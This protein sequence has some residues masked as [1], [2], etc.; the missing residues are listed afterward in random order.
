MDGGDDCIAANKQAELVDVYAY[1]D[2]I[3]STMGMSPE[4]VDGRVR[5]RWSGLAA[6]PG[7]MQLECL[8]SPST[9]TVSS[10]MNIPGGEIS[11]ECD[12][13]RVWC[14][15]LG[16]N[17]NMSTFNMKTFAPNGTLTATQSLSILPTFTTALGEP[18]SSFLRFDC[19]VYDPTSP[20]APID[21]GVLSA[22][23]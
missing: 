11:T 18:G 6:A 17:R 1:R 14:M 2:W 19:A 13:V 9:S 22:A 23:L 21:G 10:T 16:T 3:T 12:R 8:S 7:T 15:S 4:Q 5:V 20:V